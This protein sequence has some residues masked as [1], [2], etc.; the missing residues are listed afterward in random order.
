MKKTILLSCILLGFTGMSGVF[1]FNFS[2]GALGHIDLIVKPDYGIAVTALQ[3]PLEDKAL[4]SL[5]GGG[6]GYIGVDFHD[7]LGVRIEVMYTAYNFRGK[8]KYEKSYAGNT[9][10]IYDSSWKYGELQIPVLIK[11]GEFMNNCF[12]GGFLGPSFLI[13]M[14]KLEGTWEGT[15]KT[16]SLKEDTSTGDTGTFSDSFHVGIVAGVEATMIIQNVEIGLDARVHLK[17]FDSAEFKTDTGRVTF[18]NE[19]NWMILIGLRAGIRF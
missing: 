1:A 14:N 4:K 19:P 6:G 12:L 16:G 7:N 2:I 15:V 8:G 18:F 17:D 3:I 10:D 5:G 13:R 9:I 11:G